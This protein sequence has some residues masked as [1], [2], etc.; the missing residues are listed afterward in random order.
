MIGENFVS[1]ANSRLHMQHTAE[2]S[3]ELCI[4]CWTKTIINAM[5]SSAF[6]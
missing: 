6:L 2:Q 5:A 1:Q 4:A 3:E